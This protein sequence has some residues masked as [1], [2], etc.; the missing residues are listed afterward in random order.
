MQGGAG[1]GSGLTYENGKKAYQKETEVHVTITGGDVTAI[2]GW[3]AA[4]IGSGARNTIAETISISDDANIQAY[5][6]GTKFAIDTRDLQ[7]DGST[8]SYT[9]GREI[10]G[11]VLQGTFVHKGTIYDQEQDPEG[12]KTIVVTNDETGES[13]ILTLMPD[14]YR[15]FATTVASEG[16]YTVYTDDKNIGQGQGR[17]FSE[18]LKDVFHIDEILASGVKYVVVGNQISDNFYLFP[19]KTIVV[20]KEV[21]VAEGLSLSDLNLTLSFAIRS[22]ETKKYFGGQQEIR[23]EN[24]KPTGKAYFVDVPD[25]T[26]D[27]LEMNGDAMMSVGDRF[28]AVELRALS[29]RDSGGTTTNNGVIGEEQWTDTVTVIN[30]YGP[31]ISNI[32]VEGVKT[33]ADANDQ[34]GLRPASITVNL[35]A[36]GEIVDTQTVTGEGDEWRFIFRDVPAEQNGQEI[37]YTVSEEAVTGYSAAYD[38]MNM[39]NTHVPETLDIAGTKTWAD[40][41]DQ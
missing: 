20:V 9:E 2:G 17:Y 7:A 34:D 6:D 40:A 11:Y 32:D 22:K 23:I 19:V 8:K 13:V 1:I 24:G 10:E 25:A 39:T 16:N 31:Y 18:T 5:A 35:L 15:S 36:N 4:G 38:G 37:T 41:N 30:T 28:G 33:W 14:G 26:Y 12:L 21:A 29:T 3:G 27:I